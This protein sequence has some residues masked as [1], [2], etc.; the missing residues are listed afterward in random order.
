[1]PLPHE[2][3]SAGLHTPPLAIDISHFG[4]MMARRLPIFLALD[5]FRELRSGTLISPA[6]SAPPTFRDIF[7]SAASAIFLRH[8][9]ILDNI[10]LAG[11]TAGIA[12]CQELQH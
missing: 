6:T 2:P 10:A 11:P 1:M 5:H 9:F 8:S 3:S 12:T 7:F 4:A